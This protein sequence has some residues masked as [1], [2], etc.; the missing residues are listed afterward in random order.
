M[1]NVEGWVLCTTLLSPLTRA[2]PDELTVETS[3]FNH[4]QVPVAGASQAENDQY[5]ASIR[6]R[7]ICRLP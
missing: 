7:F 5:G 1:L 2:F 3:S 6:P 4:A